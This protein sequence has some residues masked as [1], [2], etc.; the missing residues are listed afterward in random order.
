MRAI[1]RWARR[2]ECSISSNRKVRLPDAHADCH[3][4]RRARRPVPDRPRPAGRAARGPV[5]V[6]WRQ[7]RA[8][9]NA[10]SGRGT[11]MPGRDGIAAEPLFRYPP[12][13]EQYDHDQVE[14]HFIGCQ[15]RGTSS[16]QPRSPF[17]W[18]ARHELSDYEFPSGN[19]AL[20]RLLTEMKPTSSY[21]PPPKCCLDSK[22]GF[23]LALPCEGLFDGSPHASSV[24]I[25]HAALSAGE[26]R[27]RAIPG[28][29]RAAATGRQYAGARGCR[30]D[31][32]ERLGYREH[33]QAD[34][35]RGVSAGG[36]VASGR[37]AANGS[38]R[39]PGFGVSGAHLGG[40]RAQACV[41]AEA[42]RYCRAIAWQHGRRQWSPGAV[43]AR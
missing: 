21:L 43:P 41:C 19:C 33:W 40:G 28:S 24:G 2:G 34:H 30:A 26:V 35:A 4:R 29:C 8:R 23:E 36:T 27:W 31:L 18:V 5:G 9:R 6:S 32:C 42:G 13:V 10:G 3:C 39:E 25:L 16:S 17:R 38:Y 20:V 12:Q 15:P 7:N 37:D 14:L 22:Q 1:T 11:R